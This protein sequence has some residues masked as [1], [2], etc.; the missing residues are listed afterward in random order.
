MIK[1]HQHAKTERENHVYLDCDLGLEYFNSFLSYIL[2]RNDGK[3]QPFFNSPEAT[4]VMT[5]LI[6]S[7]RMMF[8][9]RQ[10]CV[11]WL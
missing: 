5:Y 2:H 11:L 8:G 4:F 7:M 10:C 6:F 9:R 3:M 1:Q